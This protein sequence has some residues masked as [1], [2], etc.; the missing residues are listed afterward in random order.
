VFTASNVEKVDPRK[1][2]FVSFDTTGAALDLLRSG[3]IQVLLGQKYFGWGSE[4][5]RILNDYVAGRKPAQVIIDSGVDV[6]T[7]DNVD[8][9]EALWKKMEAGGK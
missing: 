5:I 7:K 9:Y 4:S 8:A 2:K 1:T 6:V 3:K